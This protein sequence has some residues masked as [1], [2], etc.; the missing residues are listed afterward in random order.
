MIHRTIRSCV[1]TTSSLFLRDL[2]QRRRSRRGQDLLRDSS[3]NDV[4]DPSLAVLVNVRDLV[5]RRA[6]RRRDLVQLR[7]V[8][9]ID[10][11][12][13]PRLDVPLRLRGVER[14]RPSVHHANV[15]LVRPDHVVPNGAGGMLIADE[16]LPVVQTVV[17]CGS[18]SGS[19]GLQRPSVCLPGSCWMTETGCKS[20]QL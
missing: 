19:G 11:R 9:R 5:L 16:Q 18:V 6:R 4:L 13:M 15:L 12:D 20:V 2:G 3:M 7:D 8:R 1:P 10:V 17:T 14:L